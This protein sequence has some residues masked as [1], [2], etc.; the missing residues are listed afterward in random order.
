MEVVSSRNPVLD[1]S[2]WTSGALSLVMRED[3]V[4]R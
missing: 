1:L 3:D 4:S 2:G